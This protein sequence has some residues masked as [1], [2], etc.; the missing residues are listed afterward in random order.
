MITEKQITVEIKIKWKKKI[1]L[2]TK[3]SLNSSDIKSLFSVNT[4]WP[5]TRK[6]Y[7]KTLQTLHRG[8]HSSIK[9]KHSIKLLNFVFENWK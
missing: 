6:N 3:K 4:T 8:L 2:F 9:M 7:C 5:T 1:I